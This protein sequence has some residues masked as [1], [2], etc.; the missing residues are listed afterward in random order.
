MNNKKSIMTFSALQILFFHLWVYIFPGNEIEA[1]FRQTAYVGVDVFFFLS[2]YSLSYRKIDNYKEFISS[3]IRS[4]YLK[5]ILFALVAWS[6]K[7]WSF[8]HFFK[9]ASGI[10]LLQKGGG[11]FL[12][13]LPFIMILY[14]VFPI[15][16]KAHHKAPFLTGILITT[17]WIIIG[18]LV[19]IFTSYTSMFIF[20]NRIPIF[21]LGFYLANTDFF[22]KILKNKSLCLILGLF[23]FSCGEILLYFYGYKNKMMI[24]FVDTFYIIAIPAAI[25]VFLVCSLIPENKVLKEIGSSTLEM[26]AIQMIFGYALANKLIILSL[27]TA[28]V[29]LFTFSIVII[30]SIFISKLLN[31]IIKR[32]FF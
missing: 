28:W 11:A 23:L 3:R 21:L 32:F 5:F 22:K 8:L 26:Y 25:G 14:L 10:N 16:Q 30:S 24:P 1:F 9:I 18:L 6:I 31:M 4:V 19:T 13:F 29:N 12:W 7:N 2:G 15:F 20:W 27:P 17:G